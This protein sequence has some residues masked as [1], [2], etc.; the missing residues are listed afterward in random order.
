MDYTDK[1][2]RRSTAAGA[3]LTDIVNWFKFDCCASRTLST[4]RADDGSVI[5]AS[6]QQQADMYQ[7]DFVHLFER[8]EFPKQRV[9]PDIE[10]DL[11]RFRQK[12]LARVSDEKMQFELDLL[13]APITDQ[14]IWAVIDGFK[15]DSAA[16]EDICSCMAEAGT[17]GVV[18]EP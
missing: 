6:S 10:A 11:E 9:R 8:W 18:G 15:K 1:N 17:R 4:W 2:L 14:E 7:E 12:R 16:G 3:G 5:A 13:N